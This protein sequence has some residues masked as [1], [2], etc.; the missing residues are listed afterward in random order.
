MYKSFIQEVKGDIKE[1]VH[2]QNNL[3]LKWRYMSTDMASVI[4]F[5]FWEK[6][7]GPGLPRFW[8]RLTK[9]VDPAYD[10][11]EPQQLVLLY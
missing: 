7:C 9:I 10:F 3:G 6:S 2:D 8:T 1:G 4:H 11:S 5:W